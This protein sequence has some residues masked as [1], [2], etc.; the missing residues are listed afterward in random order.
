MVP[1]KTV[2]LAVKYARKPTAA[3]MNDSMAGDTVR[4]RQCLNI[5]HVSKL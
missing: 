4:N 2:P 1:R 3:I 5:R